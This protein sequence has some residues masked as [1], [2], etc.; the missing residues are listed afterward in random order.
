MKHLL[1]TRL[2][3]NCISGTPEPIW[4]DDVITETFC[5]CDDGTYGLTCL[6]N[7]SNPCV[8]RN[9]YARADISIAKNYFIK[10]TAKIPYLM[11]C[12]PGTKWNQEILTW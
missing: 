8:Q 7:F 4:E 11:K 12:A 3:N 10:C 1:S 5:R 9:V 2:E 6:E